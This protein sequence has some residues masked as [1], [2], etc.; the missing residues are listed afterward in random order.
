[1]FERILVPLDGS[2]RAERILDPVEGLASEM[3]S[4]LVLLQVTNFYQIGM[5]APT[6]FAE[7]TINLEADWRVYQQ[8]I[9]AAEK[10]LDELCKKFNDKNIPCKSIVS[11]GEVVSSILKTADAESVDLIAIASHGHTGLAS[12][13][14]GSVAAGVLHKADRPLLLIRSED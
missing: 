1:M 13:F 5:I 9:G 2:K 6:T 8:T 11:Q 12:V 10:Y 14:Y 3:N 4:S 7:H